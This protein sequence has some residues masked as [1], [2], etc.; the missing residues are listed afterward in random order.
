MNRIKINTPCNENWDHMT[1]EGKNK[2]CVSC[3][4][5]VH[6]FSTSSTNEIIQFLK[7]SNG[8]K[9]C[10][11]LTKNQIKQ[12]NLQLQESKGSVEKIVKPGI[13]AASI[14]MASCGVTKSTSCESTLESKYK[15]INS[16]IHTNLS[17]TIF[18][19][20]QIKEL[21]GE[22]IPW[23][24]VVVENTKIGTTSDIDGRFQLIIPKSQV[25]C[26]TLKVIASFIG[27]Q[28]Q[29]IELNEVKNTEIELYIEESDN[30][31]GDIVI[32]PPLH[33]RIWYKIKYWFRS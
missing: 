12:V 17:D 20:G 18:V 21:N 2:F 15:I 9:T 8:S 13:V 32:D 1:P 14:F 10:G 30:L 29:T 26:D 7:A 23:V 11:R 19:E 4:S 22:S 28:T 3:Q 25:N 16:N 5:I 33:K 27:Y 31:M 24:N 6:D